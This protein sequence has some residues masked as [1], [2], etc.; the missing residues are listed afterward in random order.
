MQHLSPTWVWGRPPFLWQT[1]CMGVF[2]GF[3]VYRLSP[4]GGYGT[5]DWL[6]QGKGW[7]LL[8]LQKAEQDLPS[9]LLQGSVSGL[10]PEQVP[11]HEDSSQR[12]GWW[13]HWSNILYYRDIWGWHERGQVDYWN[14]ISPN[15]MI[16]SITGWVCRFSGKRTSQQYWHNWLSERNSI[17]WPGCSRGK[18][19]SVG[20]TI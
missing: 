5:S 8:S 17:G 10:H 7:W 13:W 2:W 4:P 19:T 3:G 20:L 9:V 16:L 11:L 12:W 1:T 15:Q 6:G 14:L 18:W